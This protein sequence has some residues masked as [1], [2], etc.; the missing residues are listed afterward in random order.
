VW[1]HSRVIFDPHIRR[2]ASLP[3]RRYGADAD[4]DGVKFSR[5]PILPPHPQNEA[6]A[7]DAN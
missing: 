7:T 1:Y 4:A 5:R 6:H 2:A 3:I